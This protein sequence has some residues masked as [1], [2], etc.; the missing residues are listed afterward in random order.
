MKRR[1]SNGESNAASVDVNVN[2]RIQ[3]YLSIY[4]SIESIVLSRP[5]CMC[6]PKG[7]LTLG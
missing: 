5:L 3:T 4:L 1:A 7:E 6:D 2:N